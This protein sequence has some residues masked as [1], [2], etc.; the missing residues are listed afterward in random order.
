[1]NQVEQ[2]WYFFLAIV[3]LAIQVCLDKFLLVILWTALAQEHKFISRALYD[4][5]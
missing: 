2:C 5:F 1:M 3:F 4:I